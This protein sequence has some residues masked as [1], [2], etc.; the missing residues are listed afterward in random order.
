M[1]TVAPE[2]GKIETKLGGV[3]EKGNGEGEKVF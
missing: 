2:L 1:A 3:V